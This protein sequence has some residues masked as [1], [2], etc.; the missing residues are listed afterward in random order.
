MT[1]DKLKTSVEKLLKLDH[2]DTLKS[3]IKT[4]PYDKTPTQKHYIDQIKHALGLTRAKHYLKRLLDTFLKPKCKDYNDINLHAWQDYTDIQTDSLWL[5]DKRD[6][7]GEHHA[8]YWGNF[9]PQ[10]PNQLLKRYTKKGDWVLDPFCGSGTTLI[11]AEKLNRNAFGIEL[12]SDM[13]TKTNTLCERLSSKNTCFHGDNTNINYN[14]LTKQLGIK[15][16]QFVIF[17]PPYWDIIAY[18]DKQN[19]HSNAK[20]LD[21]F[22]EMLKKTCINAC[23]ILEPGRFCA[24][25][26]SDKYQDSQWLPLGFFAMQSFQETGLQLK[27]IVVKNFNKTKGKQNQEALWRYRALQGGYYVF[28]HEY[29]FIFQ[30][31]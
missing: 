26:I 28:K 27:S 4:I 2:L 24:L 1:Q 14:T 17:H 31:P 7:S 8:G 20:H 21:H 15:Q 9:V 10:I 25:I 19:D 3:Q 5:F 13:V 23:S 12:N 6:Q 29:I 22:L 30:K 18:S 16:V 11:E